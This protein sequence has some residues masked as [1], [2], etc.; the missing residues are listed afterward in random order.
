MCY[1]GPAQPVPPET[2]PQKAFDRLFGPS[3]KDRTDRRKSVLDA[4]DHDLAALQ[5]QLGKDDAQKVGA[6]LDAV[7]A[8]EKRLAIPAACDASSL[9][10]PAEPSFTLDGQA[11]MDI[12][13]RALACDL[14]RVATLQWSAS[15][16]NVVSSTQPGRRVAR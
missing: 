11:Q 12:L 8:I 5:K 9:L 6:H 1:L 4:V 10:L 13:V 2:S 7:R 3:S 16:S 14:T 15:T